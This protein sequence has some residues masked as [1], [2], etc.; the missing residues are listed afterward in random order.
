MLGFFRLEE[1]PECAIL[2]WSKIG[3]QYCPV[4]SVT[5]IYMPGRLIWEKNPKIISVQGG[6]LRQLLGSLGS[7]DSVEWEI[8]SRTLFL[9][10]QSYDCYCNFISVCIFKIVQLLQS[11]IWVS[12]YVVTTDK[13]WFLCLDGCVGSNFEYRSCCVCPPLMRTILSLFLVLC[14]TF[15]ILIHRDHILRKRQ[16]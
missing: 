3:I 13:V 9:A 11:I 15:C 12:L 5:W 6:R 4:W 8:R 2:M 14:N 16:C 7:R 1:K 10:V